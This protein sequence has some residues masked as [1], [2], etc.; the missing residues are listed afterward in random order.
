MKENDYRILI[1]S[2][3]GNDTFIN[4]ITVA[5]EYNY[6]ILTQDVL[7][8]KK[9][10]ST[11]SSLSNIEKSSSSNILENKLKLVRNLPGYKSLE[12]RMLQK[13]E[14]IGTEISRMIVLKDLK[15]NSTSDFLDLVILA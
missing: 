2:I 11:S 8:T 9:Q 4:E 7:P 10:I 14:A 1:T 15:S 3:F 5:L 6:P 13:K 12:K